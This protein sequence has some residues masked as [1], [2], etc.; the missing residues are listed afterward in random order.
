M[1]TLLTL[2]SLQNIS[3]MTKPPQSATSSK[4]ANIIAVLSLLG[5]GAFLLLR[6]VFDRGH[7]HYTLSLHT[8]LASPLAKVYE[9]QFAYQMSLGELPLVAV[10]ILGGIPLVYQLTLKLFQG[11]FGADLLAGLL[12][13]CR[14][15]P[16]QLRIG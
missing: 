4:S 14:R 13:G 6:Y 12:L 9:A 8:S 10:L 16:R 2:G 7:E 15:Q 11:D 5:I 1:R 3:I